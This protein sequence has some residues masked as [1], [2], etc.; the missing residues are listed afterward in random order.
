[1]PLCMHHPTL[2]ERVRKKN[3]ISDGRFASSHTSRLEYS[4][5]SGDLPLLEHEHSTGE[6]HHQPALI[7]FGHNFGF[8]LQ[9][10]DS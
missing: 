9:G 3:Y 10:V 2:L 8:F 7:F 5:R 6:P 4:Q 1:M